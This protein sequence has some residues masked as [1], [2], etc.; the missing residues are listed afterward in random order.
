MLEHENRSNV[1]LKKK[2]HSDEIKLTTLQKQSEQDHAELNDLKSKFRECE[3][4]LHYLQ[5]LIDDS[6]EIELF[7]VLK[8]RKSAFH[9]SI[10]MFVYIFHIFSSRLYT[11]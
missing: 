11:V 3:Q 1:Q 8:Y 2:I 4:S 5:G 9:Q 6:S 10:H 7:V